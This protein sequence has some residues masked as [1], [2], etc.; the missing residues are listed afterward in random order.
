[1]TRTAIATA[2]ERDPRRAALL[3]R[4][5]RLLRAAGSLK[6]DRSECCGTGRCPNCPWGCP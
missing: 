2:Q 1:M 3:A 6:R 5:A 4:I